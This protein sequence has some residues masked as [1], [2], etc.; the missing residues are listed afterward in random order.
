MGKTALSVLALLLAAGTALPARERPELHG[1]APRVSTVFRQARP[2]GSKDTVRVMVMGDVM[3]HER[4]LSHEFSGFLEQLA[5]AMKAADFTAVNMEFSLGGE[6][7][8]GYPAFSAPDS[9]AFV[10]ARQCGTDIFLTANNHILDRGSSGLKRTLEVYSKM[11]DSLGTRYTGSAAD[12]LDYQASNPLVILGKGI[13]IA[14]LNFTYGTNGSGREEWPKV[15]RMRKDEILRDI[16]RAEAR[17]ADFIIALPHWGT[18]YSLRHDPVQE[19]WANWLIDNGVDAIVGSHP[20]VVQ[21]TAHINGRPVIYSTGNVVSNMS[22]ENT[23]LGL[24]VMLGFVNDT[25]SGEKYMLEPEL[26]F[27]WCC[28]PGM[29]SD[30]YNSI[31]VKEWACRR[32]DWLTPSDFD[33]MAATLDRVMEAAGISPTR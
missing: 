18:E 26:M 14:L 10:L 33:N 13:R 5:P 7:Y 9:I 11:R 28:L 3:L 12:S 15:S 1:A 22:A 27:T 8:S 29:L 20:H 25:A 32:D 30:N 23:R 4:Q 21:D 16:R 17:G 24:S 6:P 31:F 19:E 2:L